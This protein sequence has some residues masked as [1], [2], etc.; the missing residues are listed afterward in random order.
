M[1]LSIPFKKNHGI[2]FVCF[3][4]VGGKILEQ[5]DEKTDLWSSIFPEPTN[6]GLSLYC[7]PTATT[8]VFRREHAVLGCAEQTCAKAGLRYVTSH[9]VSKQKNNNNNNT[10][11]ERDVQS[12]AFRVRSCCLTGPKYSPDDLFFAPSEVAL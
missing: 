1:S 11:D 2:Y 6:Q 7:R 8:A 9:R 12:A 3:F 4:V 10:T 5:H